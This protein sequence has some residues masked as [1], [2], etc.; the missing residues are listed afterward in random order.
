MRFILIASVIALTTNLLE[1]HNQLATISEDLQKMC[2]DHVPVGSS[3]DLQKALVCGINL[4]NS[5]VWKKMFVQTG[6]I[7]VIVVSGT[8]F[9]TLI[10]LLNLFLKGRGQRFAIVLVLTAYALIT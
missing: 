7:H 8:H 2:A 6:L 3:Q 4:E 10:L 1:L 9:L 5:S